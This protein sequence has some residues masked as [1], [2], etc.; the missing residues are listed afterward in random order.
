M[1]I[2]YYVTAENEFFNDPLGSNFNIARD[3]L[4]LLKT[5]VCER[6]RENNSVLRRIYIVCWSARIHQQKKYQAT[7]NFH[8]TKPRSSFEPKSLDQPNN[9]RYY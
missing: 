7:V 5:Q 9:H 3:I 6:P 1:L 4:T 2:C 8:F